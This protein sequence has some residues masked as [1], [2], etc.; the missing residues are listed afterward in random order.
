MRDT[1]S[2][3]RAASQLSSHHLNRLR[4]F[5][6]DANAVAFNLP[7]DNDD[8]FRD[9]NLFS[10][11]PRK[12]QHDLLSLSITFGCAANHLRHALRGAA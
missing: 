7:D 8:I 1:P 3:W 12:N 2:R 10:Y 9:T 4:C 11:L 5:N 6:S